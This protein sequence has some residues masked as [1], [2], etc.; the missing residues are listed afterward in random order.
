MAVVIFVVGREMI[1]VA[2]WF[3]WWFIVLF[4]CAGIC[5]VLASLLAFGGLVDVCGGRVGGEGVAVQLWS[6]LVPPVVLLS[7]MSCISSYVCLCALVCCVRCR[8]SRFWLLK[9]VRH[10]HVL[11]ALTIRRI[12]IGID[13]CDCPFLIVWLRFMS[14]QCTCFPSVGFGFVGVVV[15]IVVWNRLCCVCCS[16]VLSSLLLGPTDIRV[17]VVVLARKWTFVARCTC[18]YLLVLYQY[19]IIVAGRVRIISTVPGT[20]TCRPEGLSTLAI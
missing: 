3:C 13:C 4:G 12:G 11:L 8:F 6:M 16:L 15:I 20:V 2:S 14:M 7:V 17:F 9:R 10:R 18:L 19:S 5:F 1:V